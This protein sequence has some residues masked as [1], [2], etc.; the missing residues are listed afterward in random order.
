MMWE[1]RDHAMRRRVKGIQS[2]AVAASTLGK[3]GAKGLVKEEQV[4]WIGD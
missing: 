1:R 3:M 2:R 4:G